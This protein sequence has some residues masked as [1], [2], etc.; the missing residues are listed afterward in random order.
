VEGVSEYEPGTV[1][2]ATVRGVPNVRVLNATGD[3]W[4]HGCGVDGDSIISAG[5]YVTD[6]RPLVTLDPEDR[7]EVVRLV[8]ALP[9]RESYDGESLVSQ[10]QAAL[11]EYAKPTPPK[12]EVYE[13]LT[14]PPRGKF[15]EAICG[16][17]WI[18][19]PD[20]TVV[21][22]CPECADIAESGWRA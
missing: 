15:V 14:Y 11:R 12:P 3:Y 4:A 5:Q 10:M 16:K 9:H 6:V 8:A 2:M 19:N 21:G 13:H 7:E 18:P 17:T 20:V 1:A 22:R